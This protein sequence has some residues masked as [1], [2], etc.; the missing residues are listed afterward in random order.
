MHYQ[1][2]P[3]KP[4]S[5]PVEGIT[6]VHYAHNN[7]LFIPCPPGQDERKRKMPAYLDEETKTWYCKFYY[8][9]YTG[10]LKQKKKRGF[11]LQRDAKEWERDFLAKHQA[12][13]T[14][15]FESFVKIYIEDMQHRLREHTLVKKQYVINKRLLP[16][17][18]KLPLS[19][20][21]PALVRKWQNELIAYRDENGKGFADTYLKCVHNQ[22]SAIFNY[23]C[24]YYNLPENPCKKAGSIGKS[25]AEEMQF[26]TTE[27]FKVFLGNVSN[28]PH[29]RAGFLIL[30][31]T[32]IRIGE[33]LA[34]EYGDIDFDGCT[35]SI[36]KSYQRIGN[37]DVVTP[38]KTPKSVRTISIPVFLR[39]ELKS[40][41]GKLYGLHRHDRIFP[42]TIYF[43]ER[44]MDR[45]TKDGTVKRIRLHDL[46]H[47]HA[48][49]LIEL[50]FSPLAIADRMGHDKVETTLN[51]YSH[52][53]PHKRDEMAEKLQDCF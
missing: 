28:K 8:R 14:M 44:E 34:L 51:T 41:T 47:S 30:Y 23:A 1:N 7:L 24:N 22:L 18:G 13:L 29:A 3:H 48:S 27:E 32:G 6:V 5:A 33:L 25:H 2:H 20:I 49:L 16:F 43:F 31:Y 38:P 11:A 12:D 52:L 40:Y 36:T 45:G 42:Y 19:E 15:S 21:S 50:G 9:D 39:D 17:F 26:W 4:R 10:E 37:R 53:F 46:R 35:L